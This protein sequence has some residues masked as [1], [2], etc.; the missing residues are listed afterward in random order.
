MSVTREQRRD[1]RTIS[2]VGLVASVSAWCGVKWNSLAAG[3]PGRFAIPPPALN[4]RK[5][6]RL[7]SALDNI[8]AQGHA[9]VAD[10]HCRRRK[11]GNHYN[12]S[13]NDSSLS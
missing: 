4:A 5:A 7:R 1:W 8:G 9:L 10:E 13:Q 11:P 2:N 12:V 6:P 3:P